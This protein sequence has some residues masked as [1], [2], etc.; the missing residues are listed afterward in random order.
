MQ[1]DATVESAEVWLNDM[2]GGLH[3]TY[4]LGDI[5][6]VDGS[7]SAGQLILT[8]NDANNTIIGGSGTNSIWGGYGYDNDVMIGGNGQNT[9]F[10]ALVNGNDVIQNAHDG[11]VID[12]TT[13]NTSEIVGT[14]ITEGGTAVGLWDGSVLEVRS[15]AAVEYK[16]ADGTYMADHASGQWVKTK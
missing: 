1:V 9:F 5:A 6:V 13:V 12:L 16:T 8:G 3:G 11:D 4:Y 7:K 14:Q 10:F 2:E 15:N